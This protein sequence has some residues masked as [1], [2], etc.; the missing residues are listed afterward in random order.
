MGQ[1]FDYWGGTV[2]VL[3]DAVSTAAKYA[4]GWLYRVYNNIGTD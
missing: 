3:S 4:N 2:L 1:V